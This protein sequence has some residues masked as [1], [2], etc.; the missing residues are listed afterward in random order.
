MPMSCTSWKQLVMWIFSP[1]RFEFLFL[2]QAEWEDVGLLGLSL[3][4]IHALTQLV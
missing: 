1:W 2:S 3:P 4:E